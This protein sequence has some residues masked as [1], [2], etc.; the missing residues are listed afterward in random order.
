[1]AS[2]FAMAAMM[3]IGQG[4]QS[5]MSQGQINNTICGVVANITKARE[6]GAIAEESIALQEQAEQQKLNKALIEVN[7]ESVHMKDM[8]DRFRTQ[9]TV[10]VVT[11]IVFVLVVAFLLIGRKVLMSRARNLMKKQLLQGETPS[12]LLIQ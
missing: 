4:V 8:Q 6:S 12:A 10:I 7:T 2:L 5:S 9:Y 11:A 3:A 1:M